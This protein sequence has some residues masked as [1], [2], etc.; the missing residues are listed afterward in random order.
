MFM[1]MR[2]KICVQMLNIETRGVLLD[3]G[4]GDGGVASFVDNDETVYIGIDINVGKLKELKLKLKRICR[5]DCELIVGDAANIPL[6]KESVKNV[7]MLEVLEHIPRSLE[8]ETILEVRRVLQRGGKVV[9]ST[10]ALNFLA[11]L[12]DP[13]FIISGHRHYSK[14]YV[15]SKLNS[16][17]FRIVKFE[18]RGYVIQALCMLIFYLMNLENYL[19]RNRTRKTGIHYSLWNLADR[20]YAKPRNNGFTLMILAEKQ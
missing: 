3:I 17:S 4:C 11:C 9:I 8:A 18:Q 2:H 6:R 16:A 19:N 15:A 10:G 14:R 13:A 1:N 20:D 5:H 7:S 12:L